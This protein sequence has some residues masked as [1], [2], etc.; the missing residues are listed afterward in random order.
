MAVWYEN[1]EVLR[2][3]EIPALQT[4]NLET[5]PRGSPGNHK[6][7]WDLGNT[8]SEKRP[9]TLKSL[10]DAEVYPLTVF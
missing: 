4:L 10:Q 8:I 9:L 2:L 6:S 7:I 5:S 3:K 1:F